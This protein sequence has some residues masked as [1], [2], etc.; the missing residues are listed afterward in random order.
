MKN[1]KILALALSAG[2]VVTGASQSFAAE[3]T[4]L[5]EETQAKVD[6]AIEKAEAN[7]E[8][9]KVEESTEPN[10]DLSISD[11]VEEEEETSEED[12]A[13]EEESTDADDTTDDDTTEEETSEEDDATE[14]AEEETE[15]PHYVIGK[16]EKEVTDED[17]E[18][19][20][21]EFVK[22]ENKEVIIDLFIKQLDQED[23]ELKEY[24]ESKFALTEEA[25]NDFRA[26]L[27]DA[28]DNGFNPEDEEFIKRLAK[29]A[30]DEFSK[31]ALI[32]Y[33]VKETIDPEVK[34]EYTDE[35]EEGQEEVV[36]EGEAGHEWYVVTEG[37]LSSL[38]KVGQYFT[39]EEV[40]ELAASGNDTLF[41]IY[42]D[43]EGNK[44]KY[45]LADLTEE[46]KQEIFGEEG[47]DRN[48]TIKPRYVIGEDGVRRP[49]KAEDEVE[50]T[51]K[52]AT[53]KIVR[54]GTGGKTVEGELWVEEL[55]P[56][57]PEELVSGEVDDL[58]EVLEETGVD[59]E[60]SEGVITGDLTFD[61][62]FSFVLPGI[63]IDPVRPAPTPTPIPE[64]KPE[65][66]EDDDVEDDIDY[67]GLADE[68]NEGSDKID[69]LLEEN[70]RKQKEANE[71]DDKDDEKETPKD[72][73]EKEV[74]GEKEDDK[75]SD[76][77][78]DKDAGKTVEKV[79]VKEVAKEKA[80]PKAKA[81]AT[82]GNPKTGVAGMS[83]VAGTLAVSMAGIVAT[84]KRN[85]K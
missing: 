47:Y 28:R 48:G 3:E 74:D 39:P 25:Q 37:P 9:F 53:P 75:E 41:V 57:D 21:E 82:H 20:A 79:V 16:R 46:Q 68:L 24:L 78:A 65:V 36:Q 73:N 10:E 1:N 52:E 66:E 72:E 22:D 12:D 85:N 8:E 61:K 64:V 62:D 58:E 2:L 69:E 51:D 42:E 6:A 59:F 32:D 63:E 17:I 84:R 35:L 15:N 44:A 83:A 55:A 33:L 38:W 60:D 49:A 31:R 4:G 76:K 50:L 40:A 5:S 77:E 26:A 11:L 30:K 23:S 80:A 27:E 19:A 45:K 13:K 70:E 7:G 56:E 29:N 54:I 43:E 14:E 18:K 81:S 71:K 67:D 34:Y